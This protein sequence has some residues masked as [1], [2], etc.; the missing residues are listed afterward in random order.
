MLAASSSAGGHGCTDQWRGEGGRWRNSPPERLEEGVE[1]GLPAPVGPT[2]PVLSAQG[3]G[4]W[5]PFYRRGTNLRRWQSEGVPYGSAEE[6]QHLGRGGRCNRGEDRGG[7][8]AAP[9][10]SN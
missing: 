9:A 3:H 2:G 4:S 8:H 7:D 6:D 1:D 5:A 10:G